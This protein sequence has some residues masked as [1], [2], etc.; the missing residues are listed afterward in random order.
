MLNV[1]LISRYNGIGCLAAVA[2]VFLVSCAAIKDPANREPIAPASSIKVSENDEQI[3]ITT[4]ELEAAVRKRGY[5]SG[6][7][8]GSFLDRATGF[9]DAGFG[10]DIVDW[11]MEPGSDEAYRDRL[12]GDLPYL[13]NNL[14]HGKRAKRSIEGPQICTRAKEL[15]TRVIR[16]TDFVAVEMNFKYTMAAPG[17]NAGVHRERGGGERGER[18]HHIDGRGGLADVGSPAVRDEDPVGEGLR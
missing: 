5:V 14:Y 11:I 18:R 13:F 12:P 1:Y 4:G 16:G 6:V 2:G 17:K 9:R 7:A 3:Q 10:L 8:G 15:P